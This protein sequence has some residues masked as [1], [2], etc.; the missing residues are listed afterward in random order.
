ML[1]CIK[2]ECTKDAPK[3]IISNKNA[4]SIKDS[5]IG[6][7]KKLLDYFLL[8][9]PNIDSYSSSNLPTIHHEEVFLEILKGKFFYKFYSDNTR[10]ELKLGEFALDGNEICSWC[11]RFVC[12]KYNKSKNL[13]N[14]ES[15]LDCLLRH[16]RNAIAHGRVFVLYKK[17]SY[18]QVLFHDVNKNGNHSAFIICNQADLKSWR[19]ILNAAVKKYGGENE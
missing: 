13:P 19:K 16:I 15:D 11:K 7:L 2:S 5:K 10:L 18:I 8:R 4:Y 12:K 9:A 14:G 17:K 6:E 3:F 1:K